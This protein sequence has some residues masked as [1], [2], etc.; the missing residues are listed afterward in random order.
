MVTDGAQGSVGHDV[1]G[2]RAIERRSGD[3]VTQGRPVRFGPFSAVL[4]ETELR[5]VA[6]DDRELVRRVHV[7]VRDP[8]WGTLRPTIEILGIADQGGR[9]EMEAHLRYRDD[10]IRFD[11]DIRIKGGE[12]GFEYEMDGT[13]GSDFAYNRIGL[14]VMLPLEG[15]VEAPYRAAGP[16]GSTTGT[17]PRHVGPQLIRGDEILP[18]FPGFDRLA[19]MTTIGYDLDLELDGDLFEMEDQRNWTDASFKIYSTP[20]ALPRPRRAAVGDRIRQV[21]QV[22]ARPRP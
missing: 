19:I 21:L 4:T 18:L 16:A 3:P 8:D 7:A 9:F 2:R 11:C 22:Q 20:L 1:L 5:Y 6:I 12:T 13:C 15:C 14:C 10:P 17:L